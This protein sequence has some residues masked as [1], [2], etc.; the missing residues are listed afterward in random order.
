MNLQIFKNPDPSGRM[1]KESFLVKNHMEEYQYIIDY[2]ISNNILDISLKEKVYLCLNDMKCI[3]TCKNL[4]CNNQVKFKNSTLGYYNY[5]SNRCVGIDPNV[6][7]LKEQKSLEKFGTKTPAQS[8]E[9]KDKS[10]KTNQERYGHNSA[11]CLLETQDK[12]KKTLLKNYGV[13]NPGKSLEIVQRRVESFKLSDY[14]ESYRKTSLKKYGVDHP[15]S[16]KDIH[17]KTIDFFYASYK[18]RVESKIDITRFKFRGFQRRI[19]TSL[20]FHCSECD[21]Q[22]DILTYQFY[23]RMNSGVNIC[24]NCFPISENASISQIEVYNFI[25][26]NYNGEVILDCKN[27]INPYEIDIYLPDLEL[28]FEFNGVWWHSE[29]F[30]GEN[31]HLKKYEISNLNG[32]HLITIW[33]DDWVTNREICESFILNKLGKTQN[34][35]YAR[36]CEIK[37]ISYNDSKGFL[38]S[39][40][41][42]GDCKSSIRIGLFNN[43]ELVSLM[44]FSKLRLPLQRQERNR[45]KESHYELTRFCNKINSN[46]IGGASKLMRYFTKKYLP[47]QIETYSDNLISNGGLYE[48]LGFK[49]SHTSKPGYW[50]VIDGIRSHR[51]NW[52]KQKLIEMGYNIDKTEEEIMSELGYYRIYNAGNK[53]WILNFENS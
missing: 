14:K 36:K 30:K 42:Q 12:S 39:N 28:G 32:V 23:Y 44:T 24:T 37:E 27:I 29:K 41:L 47:I 21:R 52:R 31:Y 19:S 49:Y 11:M 34:R 5:C 26:R 16:N 10:M 4:N 33:E 7:K 50:Y 43:E 3:P 40:H 35:I 25:K 1:C 9:V 2:C 17:S 13:D 6:I 45:K 51:F 46:V 15:W 48:V 38:D 53:K 8:K 22:F 18:S 20:L